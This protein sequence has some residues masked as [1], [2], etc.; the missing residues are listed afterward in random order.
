MKKIRI[1][2]ADDHALMRLGLKSM[3]ELEP[4]MDIVGECANG[5]EAVK[6]VAALSPD[7]VVLDLMMP[8]LNG[9]DATREILKIRPG[10]KIV[11]L[12][13]F[14]SS[15]ELR[16]AIAFGALGMQPK[17]DPTENL[18]RTIRSVFRGEPSFPP[19]VRSM[20]DAPSIQNQLTERQRNILLLVAKGVPNKQIADRFGISESGVKK[21]MQLIF[22]KIGAS[23]RAEAVAIALSRLMLG[24]E[25]SL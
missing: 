7:V 14:G 18:I 16:R 19:E 12:P 10:T 15:A 13:S 23:N 11:I 17:E 21:H 1:F 5:I 22:A 3:L 2:V 20:L 25:A 8:M 6:Q 24:D 9:A 4:D